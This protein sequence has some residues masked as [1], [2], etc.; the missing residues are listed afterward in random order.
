MIEIRYPNFTAINEKELASQIKSYLYQLADQLN[1]ALNSK[2]TTQ[3]QRFVTTEETAQVQT[4]SHI[5]KELSRISE[6]L[7]N[8]GNALELISARIQTKLVF[9]VE[10]FSIKTMYSDF[11][12]NGQPDQSFLIFGDDN[13]KIIQGIAKVSNIGT[14]RWSG[15]EGVA[16][17]SNSDGTLTV[18]LPQKA[19]GNYT[20][21]SGQKFII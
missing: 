13:G 11:S 1:Y 6:S 14:T 16:L 2:M 10:S 15:T 5:T 20:V 19:Y 3:G 4:L 8:I 12:G 9:D 7:S 17:I 18:L 21:I